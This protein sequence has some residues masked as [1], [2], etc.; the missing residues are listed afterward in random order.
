MDGP[1]KKKVTYKQ[2]RKSIEYIQ[3]ITIHTYEKFQLPLHY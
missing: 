2:T 3:R 1:E